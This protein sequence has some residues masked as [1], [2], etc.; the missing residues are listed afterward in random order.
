MTYGYQQVNSS[1][2][3]QIDDTYQ[4]L[5][6]IASGTSTMGSV[7]T[8]PASSITP[9]IAVNCTSDVYFLMYALDS[10]SFI[11]MN[12]DGGSATP[13][14]YNVYSTAPSPAPA[15]TGYGMRV[16]NSSGLLNFD[17]NYSYMAI[18]Y[19]IS[20]S[21][22]SSLLPP[23]PGTAFSV[24]HNLGFSPYVMCTLTPFTRV[25]DIGNYFDGMHDIA[26]YYL[27][28]NTS[29]AD[30]ISFIETGDFRNV[31]QG[32]GPS[33]GSIFPGIPVLLGR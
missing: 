27:C 23:T 15:G 11:I 10:T 25:E 5:G 6:A 12:S 21:T 20:G 1:G 17:S 16:Y 29:N 30:T 18:Q 26:Y 32:S 28:F 22:I 2:I 4:N 24:T 9:I 7:V 13:Y 8:F 33:G 14:S 31:P 19:I 3:V